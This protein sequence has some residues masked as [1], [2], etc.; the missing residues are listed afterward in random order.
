MDTSR[1][2]DVMRDKMENFDVAK[3]KQWRKKQKQVD[4]ERLVNKAYK[5]VGK[6]QCM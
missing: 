6:R 5:V 4:D 2:E 1:S 3:V